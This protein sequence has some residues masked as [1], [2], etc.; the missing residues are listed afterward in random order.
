MGYP[1]CPMNRVSKAHTVSVLEQ[2]FNKNVAC[3]V[4][5]VRAGGHDIPSRGPMRLLGNDVGPP[6]QMD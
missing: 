1:S 3:L 4:P 5:L 2:L 6:Q